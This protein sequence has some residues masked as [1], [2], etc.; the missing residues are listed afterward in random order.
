MT[1]RFEVGQ[2][3]KH[4]FYGVVEIAYGP[5]TSLY[6]GSR[7]VVRVDDGTENTCASGQL[8]AI[9]EPPKFAVGDKVTHRTFGAGEIAFGPFKHAT[10][11]DHY[12]MEDED[13]DHVL[14]SPDALTKVQE[15]IKVGDRVRV[16]KDDPD[17]RTGA[18]VGRVG[19]LTDM[20]GVYTA[21]LVE[22]GDGSGRHG[23]PE[24][25]RWWCAEVERV[26][27]EDTYDHDGVTYDLK[28]QY[29]DTDGDIWVFKRVG[30]VVRGDFG[31]TGQDVSARVHEGSTSLESAVRDFGPLIRVND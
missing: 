7:Y 10:G 29:Q 26:T 30:G 18:F 14:S 27:D 8:S 6:G 5:Y 12:L 20:D 2:K 25:G 9:P 17:N 22:F 28:A 1:E 15:S 24:N 16:V 23:D 31:A 13:G 3:I 11:P 4:N 21:Y 19:R